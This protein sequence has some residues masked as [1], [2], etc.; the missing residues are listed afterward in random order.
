M[1]RCA[2]TMPAE[3]A[4]LAKHH[5]KIARRICR[6]RGAEPEGNVLVAWGYDLAELHKLGHAA[7]PYWPLWQL[8]MREAQAV[9]RGFAPMPGRNV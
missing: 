7:R 2:F 3:R 9:L 4:H 8:F 5:E 6:D 1:I